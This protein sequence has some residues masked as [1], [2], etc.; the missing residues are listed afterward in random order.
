M[1]IPPA[2][3]VGV[4]VAASESVPDALGNVGQG[5]LGSAL[6]NIAS[7]AAPGIK[8]QM[9][10][11]ATTKAVAN[12]D[13]SSSGPAPDTDTGSTDY[14]GAIGGL[15]IGGTAGARPTDAYQGGL[16]PIAKGLLQAPTFDYKAALGQ[17]DN[18][19]NRG[20]LHGNPFAP[21]YNTSQQ[22]NQ[23]LLSPFEYNNRNI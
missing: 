22:G 12:A 16:A 9:L 3:K 19:R 17:R 6:G 20:L 7:N 13:L 21:R 8:G 23:G 1:G 2:I 14:S 5:L 15:N 4:N 10:G 18:G 11:M